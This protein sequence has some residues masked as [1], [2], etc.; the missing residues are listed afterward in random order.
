MEMNGAMWIKYLN[1][2]IS[3][4]L[5]VGIGLVLYRGL[6]KIKTFSI[7]GGILQ[8]TFARKRLD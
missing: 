6:K 5:L 8:I 2:G 4:F 7:S 1:E 3:F